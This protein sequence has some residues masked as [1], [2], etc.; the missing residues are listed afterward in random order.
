M[1]LD[2]GPNYWLVQYKLPKVKLIVRNQLIQVLCST[3]T[4]R[5]TCFA[6]V[7]GIG[8]PD[9]VEIREGT[10]VIGQREHVT[11]QNDRKLRDGTFAI[12]LSPANAGQLKQISPII[13]DNTHQKKTYPPWQCDCMCCFHTYCTKLHVNTLLIFYKSHNGPRCWPKLLTGA[14]QIAQSEVNLHN[15]MIGTLACDNQVGVLGLE[16]WPINV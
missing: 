9:G 4:G 13:P 2:V 11:T 14:M 5:V 15:I 3:A 16:P 1:A 6:D 10:P 12:C 8:I 7:L